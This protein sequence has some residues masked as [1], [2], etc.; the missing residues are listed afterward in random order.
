MGDDNHTTMA[1]AGAGPIAMGEL[2]LPVAGVKHQST[3]SQGRSEGGSSPGVTP[4]RIDREVVT[5]RSDLCPDF[6]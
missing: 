2:G 1:A 3:D 5:H 4:S 6:G